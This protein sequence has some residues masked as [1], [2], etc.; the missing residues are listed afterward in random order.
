MLLCPL[1]ATAYGQKVSDKAA[2]DWCKSQYQK[3]SER[4]IRCKL[5]IKYGVVKTTP[6]PAS[7]EQGKLW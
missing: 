1:N 3:N 2:A 4:C 5:G 7:K 6:A